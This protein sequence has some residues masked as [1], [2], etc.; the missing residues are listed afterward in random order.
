MR[1]RRRGLRR[2]AWPGALGIDLV[3][4]VWPVAA[5]GAVLASGLLSAYGLVPGVVPTVVQW[6]AA[7]VVLASAGAMVWRLAGR[8]ARLGMLVERLRAADADCDRRAVT[9]T[10]ARE[11]H[12]AVSR[13]LAVISVQAGLAQY[14]FA[15]DPD[16]ARAAVDTIAAT[17]H[18]A[19]D[20]LRRMRPLLR[21]GPDG[22]SGRR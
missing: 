11:S 2:P 15:T 9:G 18:E 10:R 14:V 19:L 7:G 8:H 6:A 16:T 3:L 5:F 13:Q 21:D 12:E 22:R 20:E 4:V 17:S 1:A